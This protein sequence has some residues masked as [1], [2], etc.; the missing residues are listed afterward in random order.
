V[1]DSSLL[2]LA[3]LAVLAGVALIWVGSQYE[4]SDGWSALELRLT[5]G[6]TLPP[7][8]HDPHSLVLQSPGGAFHQLYNLSTAAE[9][10]SLVGTNS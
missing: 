2:V 4:L 6:G 1:G 3:V 9:G 5:D 10:L 7:D 8:P